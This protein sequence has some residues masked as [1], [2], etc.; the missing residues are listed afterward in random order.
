VTLF[1]D[2][3]VRTEWPLGFVAPALAIVLG[4]V[5]GIAGDVSESL[6]KPSADMI[7]SN[8]E[9]LDDDALLADAVEFT[10]DCF[11]L[12]CVWCVAAIAVKKRVRKFPEGLVARAG[13][14]SRRSQICAFFKLHRQIRTRQTRN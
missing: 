5:D 11:S 2:F 14:V 7:E 12:G 10:S 1:C 6:L 13:P 8:V 4:L 9:G 3:A